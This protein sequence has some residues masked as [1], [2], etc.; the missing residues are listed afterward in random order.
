M[1]RGRLINHFNNND[2]VNFEKPVGEKISI[3]KDRVRREIRKPDRF[4][5]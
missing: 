5:E 3:A 1:A 2:K 4:R